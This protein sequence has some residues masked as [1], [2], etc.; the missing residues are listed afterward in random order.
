VGR[1]TNTKLQKIIKIDEELN[2]IQDLDI[3]MERI[4][5]D[6]RRVTNAEAGSVYTVEGNELR[7]KS[8]QNEELERDLPPNGKLIY[9]FLKYPISEKTI[10]GWVAANAEPLMIT[11]MYNIPDEEP[12]SF[13]TEYDKKSGYKTVSSLTLPLVSNQDQLLGV[14]QLINARDKKGDITPFH[15]DD[16]PFVMHFASSA[17]LALQRAQMTR[18]LLLRMIRMAGLRD[19]KE[20]G[21]HVNRVGAYSV[22][23]YEAWAKNRSIPFSEIEKV[24]DVFRMVAMLHDIGKVA[25]PDNILKKA[26]LLDEA[27]FTVMK[28]HTWQGAKIMGDSESLMDSMAIEVALRHH[29]HWDGSG[30]PGRIDTDTGEWLDEQDQSGLK[31][32]E[33][34][35]FARIVAIADVFDA[36][37]SHRV[38]KKAWKEEDVIN[39]LI[40]QKGKQFDPELVDLFIEILPTIKHVQ[41]RYPDQEE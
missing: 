2:K 4:L 25:I 24:K 32:E 20:T 39:S 27:E 6:A 17:T 21:A 14:L 12:Y 18:T 15:K 3:L 30:Y 40:E 11:D 31:G 1:I 34:P 7:I 13:S 16:V 33:I 8:S 26:G 38:Y 9:A 28:T 23:I 35:L 22:E 29:E 41:K 36:L 10:S 19:P 5:L 37:M